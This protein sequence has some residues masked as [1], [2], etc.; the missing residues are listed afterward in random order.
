MANLE[1]SQGSLPFDAIVLAG[2]RSTRLGRNKLNE[3]LGPQTVLERVVTSLGL[4]DTIVIVGTDQTVDI[5]KLRWATERTTEALIMMTE[6]PAG[7]GPAMGIAAGVRGLGESKPEKHTV[8]LGGDMPFVTRAVPALLG[9]LTGHQAAVLI[10]NDNQ[11]QY[12]AS[13]WQ[14]RALLTATAHTKPGDSVRSIFTEINAAQIHDLYDASLDIDTE[15]DL[16]RA[17]AKLDAAPP[18]PPPSS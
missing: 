17:I 15:S 18:K 12:L 3:S 11:V 10:D 14:H 5:A 1:S 7:S 9:A 16:G 4:A 13:A 8:V 6:E 2:G